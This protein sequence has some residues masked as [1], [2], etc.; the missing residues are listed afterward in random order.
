MHVISHHEMSGYLKSKLGIKLM[1][2]DFRELTTVERL[3]SSPLTSQI[4]QQINKTSTPSVSVMPV[5]AVRAPPL[6]SLNAL[7]CIKV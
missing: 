4:I 5:L 2:K 1:H 6:L 7:R 3:P